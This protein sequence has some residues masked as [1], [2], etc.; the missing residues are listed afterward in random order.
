MQTRAT[1]STPS[2]DATDAAG[3]GVTPVGKRFVTI[4]GPEGTDRFGHGLA[5]GVIAGPCAIES[6]DLCVS[7]AEHLAEVCGKLRLPYVFK[8]SF[9][10]ANR[11]SA[12][13]PRGPGL[14][15]GLAVLDA[16]RT[17]VGVPVTTDIHHPEQ[18]AAAAAVVD[19]LQIPAFLCRQTDLLVAASEAAAT[20]QR[21]VNIKKGQFLS[22]EEMAGPVRKCRAAGC[23]NLLL[24]ERGT[25]FGYHRL[26]TDLIGLGD[27]MQLDPE[28]AAGRPFDAT[29][30]PRG[31]PPVC[32]DATHSA[33]LP[34][35]GSTSG[36]RRERVPMLARAAVAAGV[37]AVFLETHP[38]PDEAISD[39]D[40]MLPMEAAGPLLRQ[41]A[42]VRDALQNT[43]AEHA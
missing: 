7:I 43:E 21:A 34:G 38:K 33:Q 20:H 42:R 13:S 3:A 12:G 6:R 31:G 35:A 26:V 37:D 14:D 9:D 4:A 25:F 23:D 27:L 15:E 39:R 36:G 32:F 28:N 10:K 22:P 11:S 29:G 16:V 24:T 40:T 30:S 17:T 8:A 18:A 1:D 41:L 5:L 2:A 19:V